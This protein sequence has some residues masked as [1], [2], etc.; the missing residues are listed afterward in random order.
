MNIP[1][2]H[3][4]VMP[5]LMVAGAAGFAAFAEQVFGATVIMTR[6]REGSTQV[7]HSELQ[8]GGSTI[9]FCDATEQWA[10]QTA[11]LFVYVPNADDTYAA[12]LSAGATVV[13]APSTQDYG[14]TCGVT[15][16][17]G[18]IWWITSVL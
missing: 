7:M 9:M 17:Y 1:P 8:I 10:P 11:N 13:M 18:N 12:A 2:T 3:Q 6:L 5:Y 16:P 15:D 14:R 4:S